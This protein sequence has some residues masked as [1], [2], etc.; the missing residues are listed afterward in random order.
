MKKKLIYLFLIIILLASFTIFTSNKDNDINEEL[1][2]EIEPIPKKIV[3]LV[4]LYFPDKG[5]QYL[6]RENRVI[7]HT[8]EQPEKLIL[9][10]LIKGP[11]NQRNADI[12][13]SNVRVYSIVTKNDITYVHLSN[14]FKS[15]MKFGSNNEVLAIYSIVNSLTE[16]KT[17][18]NVR[19]IVEGEEADVLQK[20]M[21]LNHVYKQDLRLVNNPIKNPIQ[22]VKDYFAFIEN[23]EYRQAFNLLYNP[24]SANVDY[25]MFY[26]YQKNKSIKKHNI[27]T[28]IMMEEAD[29]RV[30]TFDYSEINTRGIEFYYNNKDFKLKNYYLFLK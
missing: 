9:E 29:F 14:E 27:Y 23:E 18:K 17:V 30:V 5:R 26:H 19:L 6:V 4:T 10:E 1:N 8:I 13:P 21:P 3:K 28:Y 15:D 24:A 16:L 22:I 2:V 12:I 25:S 7:E 20:Y 11:V